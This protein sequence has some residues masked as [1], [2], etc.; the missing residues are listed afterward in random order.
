MSAITL[1]LAIAFGVWLVN[2][3]TILAKIVR[4]SRSNLALYL[5]LY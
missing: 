1:L 5:I 2:A 3:K 4:K